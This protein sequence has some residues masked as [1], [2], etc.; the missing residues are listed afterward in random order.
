MPNCIYCK[1]TKPASSF[2]NEHVLSRAFCGEGV[3]WTLA[4]TVCK[5]CNERFSAFEAHWSR[6][7]IE[8]MMRN[9]SGPSGRTGRSTATRRQPIDC[10]HIYIV[11]RND[12]LVYEAGFAFPNHHYLRPQILHTSDG[13]VCLVSAHADI[14]ELRAAIDDMIKGGTF[15]VSKP[16]AGGSEKGFEVATLMLN[17]D[18]EECS[19]V[20][21]RTEEKATGYWL[22]SFPVPPSIQ[23]LNGVVG[24]LTPRCALDDRNRLY[25]RANDWAGVTLLLTDMVK[26][27]NA[28]PS[29]GSN[30]EET[31]HIRHVIKLPLVYRAVMKTGLNFVAKVAGS[32]VAHDSMFDQLRRIILDPAADEEV[33][34]QCRI[35]S[36]TAEGDPTRVSFPPPSSIDEHRLML[37]EHAGTLRFRIR[38]YGTLGYECDLG[39]TTSTVQGR[40]T[41]A[42]AVVDFA[43]EGIREVAEWT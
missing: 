12:D 9:F 17:F 42:R 40:I 8:G 32:A 31:V 29:E 14:G 3:N 24:T 20:A 6:S 38:L 7:A 10:D 4:E 11:R 16:I 2:S 43:G 28:T 23:G 27:R 5:Q 37:D 26:N 15:E 30:H 25:F 13:V 21:T 34:G 36:D 39:R 35:L 41:T 19:R 1:A 22:R 18:T 33:M